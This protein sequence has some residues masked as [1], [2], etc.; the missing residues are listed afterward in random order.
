MINDKDTDVVNDPISVP[1][2]RDKEKEKDDIFN[3]LRNSILNIL[4][5]PSKVVFYDRQIYSPYQKF[6]NEIK[7]FNRILYCLLVIASTLNNSSDIIFFC[8]VSVSDL[9]N[10]PKMFCNFPHSLLGSTF[11]K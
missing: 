2:D 4:L 7:F 5:E 6:L 3:E 1:N 9:T 11:M 8:T 10:F